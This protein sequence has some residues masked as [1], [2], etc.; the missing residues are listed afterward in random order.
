MIAPLAAQAD[1]TAARALI[2]DCGLRFEP[3]FDDLLGVHVEGE[4]AAVGA[5]AGCVLK[6]LAVSPAHRG[7]PLLG[8]LLSALV[9]NGLDAG[10]ETLFV[11]TKPPL[12][13]SFTA[14]GFTL[15]AA[16]ER[17]AWLEF[18]HGF[19][20]ALADLEPLRKPGAN[21]ALYLQGDPLGMAARRALRAA[22]ASVDHLYV[23]AAGVPPPCDD[24]HASRPQ[25]VSRGLARVTVVDLGLYRTPDRFPTYFL[26]PDDPVAAFRAELD[27]LLFATHVA[28]RLGVVRCFA[29]AGSALPPA[30]A[31]HIFAQ[32][33][34]EVALLAPQGEALCAPSPASLYGFPG[35]TP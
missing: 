5:R 27:A 12:T 6:M 31:G 23:F 28:P 32:H 1:V 14:L 13:R 9:A 15:L 11:F 16:Q 18:G 21:G 19:Q 25:G 7:G 22:S 3:A 20:H 8:E 17:V 29:A 24:Q 30:A 2:A 33:G 26:A 34:I 10:C 4:L 35:D